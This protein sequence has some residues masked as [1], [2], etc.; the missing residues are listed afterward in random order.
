MRI[1]YGYNS[2]NER[3][4]TVE[5]VERRAP[6]YQSAVR[7]N[8]SSPQLRETREEPAG[9]GNVRSSYRPRFIQKL[10]DDSTPKPVVNPPMTSSVF[11]KR[12]A[13]SPKKKS[14]SSPKKGGNL[15]SKSTTKKRNPSPMTKSD[16]IYTPSGQA[17]YV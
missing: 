16:A 14:Q 15:T 10:L 2:K 9:S 4:G 8:A 12:R 17:I 1:E 6:Q 7:E 11:K 3:V 5:I 13:S